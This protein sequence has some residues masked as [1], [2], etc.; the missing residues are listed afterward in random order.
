MTSHSFTPDEGQEIDRLIRTMQGSGAGPT[1]LSEMLRGWESLVIAVE[2]GYDDSIY[3]FT[4]DLSIRDLLAHL[5]QLAPAPLA[6]KLEQVLT[7]LDVRFDA[8]TKIAKRP[9]APSSAASWWWA[10][11]PRL[12]VGELAA[13]LQDLDYE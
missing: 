2:R 12:Q 4:N 7:P 13:D 8:A 3:E 11:V 9:L 10:R 5:E 1:S 6:T